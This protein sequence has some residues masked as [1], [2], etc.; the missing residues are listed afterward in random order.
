MGQTS[1]GE[2]LP[3]LRHC[4]KDAAPEIVRAAI[5]AL[6]NWADPAPL[7]DL[8][9][10]AKSS[11]NPT[12]QVLASRG[13]LKLMAIPSQRPNPE[14]ARLLGEAM[15]LAKEPAEKR[16]VLS[17]LLTYPCKESLKLAEALLGDAAVADE[18]KAAVD[19]IIY[20]L[21]PR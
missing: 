14:S 7:A 5:L 19:R 8:A 18:A 9:A 16:T 17:L 4:L 12:Q 10:V 3:L 21:K 13:Y 1:S 2:A 20:L 11:T 6:S 15:Q